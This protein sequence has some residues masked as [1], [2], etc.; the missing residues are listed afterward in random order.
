M[1]NTLSAY[2][3]LIVWIGIL[4]FSLSAYS[5]P[6]RWSESVDETFVFKI[7]DDEA[8]KLMKGDFKEKHRMKMLASPFASFKDSWEGQPEKG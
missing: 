1:S 2:R 5:Q 8:L 4:F 3:I 7:N 6:L